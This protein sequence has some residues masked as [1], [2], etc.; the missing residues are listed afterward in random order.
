MVVSIGLGL[1]GMV[2]GVLAAVKSVWFLVP[3]SWS[4]RLMCPVVGV[5]PNG[6]RL[7]IGDPLLDPSVIPIGILVSLAFFVALSALTGLWFSKREVW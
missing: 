3:W 4:L 2:A 5:H 7:A 1:F 6:V